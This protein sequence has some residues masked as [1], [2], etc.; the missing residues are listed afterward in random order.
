MT[1]FCEVI[2]ICDHILPFF[3]IHMFFQYV[4]DQSIYHLVIY[5]VPF[6]LWF[7]P[8]FKALRHWAIFCVFL[9]YCS[10]LALALL[11]LLALLHFLT[12]VYRHAQKSGKPFIGLP[13]N[14]LLSVIYSPFATALGSLR[15]SHISEITIN[16]RFSST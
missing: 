15:V 14:I 11:A 9:C 5:H 7:L 8:R 4:K 16:S 3:C 2:A 10:F 1:I 13:L 12:S 6:G